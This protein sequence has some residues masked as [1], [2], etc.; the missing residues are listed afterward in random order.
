[1]DDEIKFEGDKLL[2]QASWQKYLPKKQL[3]QA[4][5]ALPFS[6][7]H[8]RLLGARMAEKLS[9]FVLIFRQEN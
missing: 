5:G 9:D 8:S 2:M 4:P 7:A 6:K 1:M 3:R